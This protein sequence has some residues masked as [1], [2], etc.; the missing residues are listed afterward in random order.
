MR[1]PMFGEGMEL[2]AKT[3]LYKLMWGDSR[4]KMNALHPGKRKK[5]FQQKKN[6]QLI[7]F[8]FSFLFRC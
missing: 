8:C 1:I 6:N 7:S 5:L 4:F 2:G 3:L